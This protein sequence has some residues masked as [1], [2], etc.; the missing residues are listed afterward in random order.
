MKVY[1]IVAVVLIAVGILGLLYGH[2][3]YNKESQGARLGPIELT[4]TEKKTVNV[5][6]WAGVGST[7]AGAAMLNFALIKHKALA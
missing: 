7:V 2:F 3:S 6:V 4:I 5:P 1:V